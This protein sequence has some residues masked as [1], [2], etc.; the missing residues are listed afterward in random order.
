MTDTTLGIASYVVYQSDGGEKLHRNPT[1]AANCIRQTDPL[2]LH[3]GNIDMSGVEM[4][5]LHECK[6][7]PDKL[8]KNCIT[9]D[10]YRRA[11]SFLRGNDD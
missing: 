10:E 3:G 1:C 5:R 7:L 11:K 2:E 8:C 4:L 9:G 6:E